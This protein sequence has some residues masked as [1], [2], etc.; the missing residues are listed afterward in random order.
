MD[1]AKP[2]AARPAVQFGV[3]GLFPCFP[4][5]VPNVGQIGLAPSSRNDDDS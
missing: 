5:A 4:P 1:V 2:A 3:I